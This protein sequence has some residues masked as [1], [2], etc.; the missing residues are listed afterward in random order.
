LAQAGD[1]LG[2]RVVGENA[3]TQRSLM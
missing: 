1:W 3:Q 2:G